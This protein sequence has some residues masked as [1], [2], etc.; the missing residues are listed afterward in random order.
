[1]SLPHVILTVLSQRE[2][3]GYDIT[4]GFSCGIGHF[5]KASHQQVYRELN[6][7]ADLKA[8]K[9][10]HELQVGKPD[11]KVYS[12]TDSGKQNLYEWFLTPA[13]HTTDR[14]EI[15][16]KLL[17][18]NV[19]VPG[20]MIEHIHILI[21]ES[22]V[23]LNHYRSQDCIQFSNTQ[24]LTRLERLEHL[25]LRRNII[26]KEAWLTWAEEVLTELN[27]MEASSSM[28]TFSPTSD[29]AVPTLV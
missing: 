10:R 21:D 28:D 19:F 8:V 9:C 16:A 11:R 15:S 27:A 26:L 3:T 6:K 14:D 24:N 5:W 20:P 23:Q 29:Q 12:I 17:A 25:T 2:A 18:C 22:R 4:K 7:L 13:K 1:M